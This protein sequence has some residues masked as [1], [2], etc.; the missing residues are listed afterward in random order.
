MSLN[1]PRPTQEMPSY[2]K[3]AL[4]ISYYDDKSIGL[5]KNPRHSTNIRSCHNS[6]WAVPSYTLTVDWLSPILLAIFEDT[7]LKF[8]IP[9]TTLA[10]K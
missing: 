5:N 2:Y 3:Y 10:K 8:I 1:K 9:E 7:G 6:T 4:F